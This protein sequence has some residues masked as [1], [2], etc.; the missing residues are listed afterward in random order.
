VI[1]LKLHAGEG[2]RVAD[3]RGR[4][5]VVRGRESEGG[6]V[7]AGEWG[8]AA[9]RERERARGLAGARGQTGGGPRGEGERARGE[10]EAAGMGRESAQSGGGGVCGG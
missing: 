6:E 8:R 2:D 5:S 10:R 3:W 1:T 4:L 7:R 9:A